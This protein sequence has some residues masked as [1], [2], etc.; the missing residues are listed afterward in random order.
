[1]LIG[2]GSLF[3][4]LELPG[5]EAVTTLRGESADRYGEFNACHYTGD[6]PAHVTM[7]RRLVADWFGVGVDRLVIPRQTHSANVAMIEGTV[8]A[9]T[10]EGVDGLVTAEPGRVLCVNTADCVPV[11]MCDP[12]RRVIAAVHSGWRGTVARIAAKAVDVMVAAGADPAD[13]YAVMGPS[14]CA[15]CFE[16]GRE[17]AD[18]FYDEFG[19]GPA[20]GVV[21]ERGGER[22]HV[23]LGRAIAATLEEAGLRPEHIAL[24]DSCSHCDGSPYFSA[25]RLGVGSGRTLTAVMLRPRTE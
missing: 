6:D 10:L 7:G 24:P 20:R 4:R 3:R 21:E 25:R 19:R 2:A 8:T 13:V 16:V 11:V 1:M 23:D 15:G 9:A 18:L 12:G 14:I 5:C 22:P 17:V